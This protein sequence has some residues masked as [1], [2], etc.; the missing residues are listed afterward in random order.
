MSSKET[1]HEQ[2][3]AVLGYA[4]TEFIAQIRKHGFVFPVEIECRDKYWTR[5]RTLRVEQNGKIVAERR[6]SKCFPIF[7]LKIVAVD[8]RRR[9]ARVRIAADSS[10]RE[11]EFLN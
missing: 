3:A 11:A 6:R 2:L 8:Q 4:L 7:P 10:A 5:L 1:E 9:V